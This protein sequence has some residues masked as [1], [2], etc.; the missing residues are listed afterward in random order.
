VLAVLVA[1]TCSYA[2]V[3]QLVLHDAVTEHG[4][5]EG[6]RMILKHLAVSTQGW[7]NPAGIT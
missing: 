4:A 5:L 7:V 1:V 2:T 3:K 6:L